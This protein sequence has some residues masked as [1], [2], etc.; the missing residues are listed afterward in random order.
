MLMPSLHHDHSWHLSRSLIELGCKRLYSALL[1]LATALALPRYLLA[2]QQACY[3][4]S[5]R[6]SLLLRVPVVLPA[7]WEIVPFALLAGSQAAHNLEQ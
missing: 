7:R 4:I 3:Q 6:L 5:A 1:R 2:I